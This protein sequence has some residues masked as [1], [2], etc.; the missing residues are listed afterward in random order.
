MVNF[1]E[2]LFGLAILAAVVA[3]V[4]LIRRRQSAARRL[5]IAAV[6]LACVGGI[7]ELYLR[8]RV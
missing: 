3:L 2:T 7:L 6:A 8:S 1:I 4:C 5:G